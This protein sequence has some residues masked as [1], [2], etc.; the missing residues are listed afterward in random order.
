MILR[1][2]ALSLALGL[3]AAPPAAAQEAL[4]L[5]ASEFSAFSR[6]TLDLPPG[7]A[8]RIEQEGRA[9]TVVLEGRRVD[10]DA[11]A[12]FP[13]RRVSRVLRASEAEAAGDSRI[14]FS[15][16]CDCEAEVYP[17]GAALVLDFRDGAAVEPPAA[18]AL[19]P[20]ATATAA[21]EI[22]AAA[23][24]APSEAH[25]DAPAPESH[26]AAGGAAA[27]A[28]RP[29]AAPDAHAAA[30]QA[31]AQQEH[32]PD[33]PPAAHQ[34]ATSSAPA[35]S[36]APDPAT[37]PA[38]AAAPREAPPQDVASVV[39]EAQRRLIEQLSRAAQEGLVE[40][41]RPLPKPPAED[42]PQ[43]PAP[44][45]SAHGGEAQAEAP[46]AAPSDPAHDGAAATEQAAAA[47]T[48][49]GEGQIEIRS[50]FERD[51]KPAPPPRDARCV[52]DAR[53]VLP[54]AEGAEDPAVAIAAYRRDLTDAKD[55]LDRAAMARLAK[56]Y[57]AIGFGAE[58]IEILRGV[59]KPLNSAPLVTD[60]ALV[61]DGLP[62]AESGPL[63]GAK[64]CS[65]VV[66]VW[67]LAVPGADG[68]ELPPG[69]AAAVD[70]SESLALVP[71]P[72]R[73]HLGAQVLTAMVDAGR[74][75]A[76]R[77]VAAVLDRAPG[78][79]SDAR[80]LA[81]AK[82]AIAEGRE[83]QADAIL[84]ALTFRSSPEASEATALVIERRLAAGEP[85]E[86]RLIDSAAA[87][88]LSYRGTPLGKRLKAAEIR[89]RGGGRF[90]EALDVLETEFE[91]EGPDDQTLREV[92]QEVFFA[93]TPEKTGAAE[94]A[95]AAIARQGMMGEGPDSDRARAATAE[96]LTAIGLANAALDMVRPGLGRS[97]EAKLAGARAQVALGEGDAA[98][99]LLDGVEGEPAE[100]TRVAALV[101]EERHD[102]AW[103][104]V[105]QDEM[106]APERRAAFAWRA[107]EWSA[108]AALAPTSP[109]APFAAWASGESPEAAAQTL[110]DLPPEQ[111]AAMG[112]PPQE[113]KPSL[114]GARALIARSRVAEQFIEEA[115]KDG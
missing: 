36:P 20:P 8:W 71:P 6:V 70:L 18:P 87:R 11:R 90:I 73:H 55:E 43:D 63:A 48:T 97:P 72:L 88:A 2:L 84:E 82:F 41:T 34:A 23:L 108:A 66:R 58:A 10:L 78:P 56:L 1:P 19:S 102:E 75:D 50:V 74:L 14:T 107:G 110:T 85:V 100:E 64:G 77:R 114:A 27:P 51:R 5:R 7:A 81:A 61:V 54:V 28:A 80:R 17:L 46:H 106:V 16:S 24:P 57:V 112:P 9:L 60:M 42:A 115:L 67:R 65:G 52:E 21:R 35:P 26:A 76:A 89:A 92:A 15:M 31:P 45:E 4:R 3:A 68:N 25:V 91:R 104:H 12:I 83:S 59:E 33:P 113:E 32:E 37:D 30:P 95:G 49:L 69:P 93:A 94:Y 39:A 86:D 105:Q 96:R 62:Y 40:F 53:F 29:Q 98:I 38:P 79:R 103:A 111:L 109:R 13:E 101:V 44:V 99:A 47:P 22:P